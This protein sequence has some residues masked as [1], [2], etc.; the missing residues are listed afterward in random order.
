M[1]SLSGPPLAKL[2]LV[3]QVDG[4]GSQRALSQSELIHDDKENRHE[5]QVVNCRCD[6]AT[7]DGC[8]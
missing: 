7:D 8:G 6:H 2:W 5:D 1:L 4:R 3:V